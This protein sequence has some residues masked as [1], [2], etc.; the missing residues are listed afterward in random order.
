FQNSAILFLL[1]LPRP[2]RS[3][4]F[5]YTTL[6]RSVDGVRPIRS[7]YHDDV[8]PSGHAVHE[9]EQLSHNST[10]HFSR[11]FLSL[12]S[13]GV[14]LVDE[15]EDRKSTRLNSSHVS[16]SYAVFCLKKKSY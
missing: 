13:D 15:Y 2:P 8:S 1:I 11:H 16:I 6:F 9:G 14:H 10:F 12:W 3:T 5:P 4:L 7:A